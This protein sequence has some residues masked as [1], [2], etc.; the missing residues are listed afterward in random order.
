MECECAKSSNRS[1]VSY[2]S[3]KECVSVSVVDEEHNRSEI[4]EMQK[5]K[6]EMSDIFVDNSN[7]GI[8]TLSKEELRDLFSME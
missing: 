5:R 8:S 3:D 6:K 4:Y 1:C 2:W 7:G